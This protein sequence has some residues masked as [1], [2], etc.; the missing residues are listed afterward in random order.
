MEHMKKT[1]FNKYEHVW[2]GELRTISDAQIFKGKWVVMDFEPWRDETPYF[3]MDFGFSADPTTVI[4]MFI[5]GT[6]LYID[7][8]QV[9]Y[10]IDFKGMPPMIRATMDKTESYHWQIQADCSRP[11]TISN[12][13]NAPYDFNIVGCKKWHGSVE[14]GI[15]YLRSFTRIIIH[16]D[17]PFTAGEFRRYSYKVDKKT[18]K[19]LPIP[20]DDYNHTI[21]AIRYGLGDLIKHKATIYDEGV[22]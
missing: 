5:R 12:L 20:I 6:D 2:L 7:R 14:D 3:G 11:E 16:P 22:I 9:G 19:I 10:H 13:K 4:R 1:N 8:E 18:N 17:C 21:D 15:E